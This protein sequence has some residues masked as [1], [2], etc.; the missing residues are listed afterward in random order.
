MDAIKEGG[1]A[2]RYQRNARRAAR[3]APTKRHCGNSLTRRDAEAA[4]LATVFL[5]VL[6]V[7]AI[8]LCGLI[9]GPDDEADLVEHAQWMQQLKE[10]GAWVMW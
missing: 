2:Y 9:G 1:R 3:R 10:E 5:V 8:L 7:L 4:T 6:L